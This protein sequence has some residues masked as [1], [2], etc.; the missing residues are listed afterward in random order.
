MPRNSTEAEVADFGTE[1]VVFDPRNRM[2]HHL[3]GWMA[4]VFDACDGTTLVADLV[5]DA[6][7]FWNGNADEAR[8]RV[9]EAI[10]ALANLGILEGADPMAPPP[11]VGCGGAERPATPRRRFGR[12]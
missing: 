6:T 5:T 7:D 4:V 1:F 11:C 2:A 3:S 9:D 10:D 8:M 12:R